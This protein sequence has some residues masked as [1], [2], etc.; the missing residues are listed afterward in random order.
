[1]LLA[2]QIASFI[3]N[4]GMWKARL[5]KVLETRTYE[6]DVSQVQRDDQ[7]EFGKWLNALTGREKSTEEYRNVKALHAE[8]HKVAAQVLD[9]ALAGRKQE[10]E[11]LLGATGPF[12]AASAKLT[13][14]M[15]TW[16]N[17]IK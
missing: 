17:S 2:D 9:H 5:R 11:T 3:G 15:M 7:C 8:F 6:Q 10:A 13:Q 12:T 4:H 16:K 1:M 14:G